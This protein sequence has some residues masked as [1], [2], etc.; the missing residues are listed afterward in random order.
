MKYRRLKREDEKGALEGL[1]LYLIILVVIAGVGT[2][3]IAGWMM[4]AE[5]TE[6]GSIEYEIPNEENTT[7]QL[8]ISEDGER[9]IYVYTYDQNGDSLE[10]V[11]VSID[12]CGA[13]D[14]DEPVERTGKEGEASF[15]V[16][17]SDLYIPEDKDHGKIEIKAEYKGDTTRTETATIL[18][19]E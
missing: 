11:T 9:T 8:D 5:S 1:P 17:K 19:T 18:V 14:I 4:S 7:G 3:I 16:E 2:A 13:G 12:G 10:G 6:L 15:K